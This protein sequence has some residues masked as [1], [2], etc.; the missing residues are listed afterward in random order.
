MSR[1]WYLVVG[2]AKTGTTAVAMTLRNTLKVPQLLMEPKNGEEIEAVRGYQRLVIKCLFDHWQSHAGELESLIKGTR[3]DPPPITIA[4]VRDPRDEAVS[5]LHYAAFAYFSSR[6]TTDGER[7]EWIEIFRRKEETP[8]S[9]GL[10]DMQEQI[11]ARF[12]SGFLA[13]KGLYEAYVRFVDGITSSASPTVYLLRYEDFVDERIP[14]EVLRRILSGD[15]D[16]GPGYRRVH[17]RGSSGDWQQFLTD[18]DLAV[19]NTTCAPFLRR[20]HYP[21]ERSGMVTKSPRATGSDYVVKLIDEARS[22]F[23]LGQRK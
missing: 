3:A 1:E 21:L 14:H 16:V 19:I 17:R 20:F 9:I 10:L 15:R 22:Q 18:R 12:G 6:P 11:Q 13:A 4:I 5:R 2:L 7:A 23:E 8:D